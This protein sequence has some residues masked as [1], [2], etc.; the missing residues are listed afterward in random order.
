MSKKIYFINLNHI[1]QE[2]KLLIFSPN[3]AVE[4]FQTIKD[5][6]LGDKVYL[7]LNKK[8]TVA[9]VTDTCKESN[10]TKNN[11]LFELFKKKDNYVKG[12]KIEKTS[13]LFLEVEPT[14]QYEL[15][16]KSSKMDVSMYIKNLITENY[17]NDLLGDE[18]KKH[19]ILFYGF[20]KANYSAKLEKDFT[21]LINKF[22]K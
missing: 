15:N 22:Y 7:F 1:K 17:S 14:K 6:K 8:L 10:K 13:Y 2:N 19:K 5:A 20:G 3:I 18:K 11:K 21:K 9:E 16:D 12:P 4:N